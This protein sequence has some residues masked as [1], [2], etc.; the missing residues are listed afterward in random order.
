MKL[1]NM[2]L[3]KAPTIKKV[4]NSL[5][6]AS[7]AFQLWSCASN[8]PIAIPN[9][10]WEKGS[11]VI[12]TKSC[13][14]ENPY[15]SD[16]GTWWEWK[17]NATNDEWKGNWEWNN[18]NK[19]GNE[20]GGG[21]WNSDTGTALTDV[22][23]QTPKPSSFS[24]DTWS[25][26]NAGREQWVGN[27]TWRNNGNFSSSNNKN[28]LWALNVVWTLPANLVTWFQFVSSIKDEEP[29]DIVLP[30]LGW[31]FD[32]SQSF[33]WKLEITVLIQGDAKVCIPWVFW[34][35]IR[36]MSISGM[37][38]NN[39]LIP[40]ISAFGYLDMTSFDQ[41]LWE[42]V[43][44]NYSVEEDPEY[45]QRLWDEVF[46]QKKEITEEERER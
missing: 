39:L 14:L 45:I 25:D 20:M 17:G 12:P 13:E 6:I 10:S 19:S 30:S 36:D 40:E 7:T 11:I 27:D 31:G 43:T 41:C 24:F 34:H 38:G 46:R 44:L 21:E 37:S 32:I 26:S 2:K 42:Y 33:D 1:W 28:P 5:L 35:K 15:S 23:S 18:S 8:K 4:V 3:W 22:L 29:T 16:F 9:D